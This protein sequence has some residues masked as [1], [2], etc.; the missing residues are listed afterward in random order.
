MALP[1]LVIAGVTKAGTSSLF[2]YLG[3]HPDI[4]VADVK[5]V[6]HYAPMVHGEPPPALVDY[7][8]HFRACAASPW[9]LEASPRYFIGGPPL[10]RRLAD[11]LDRPKVLIALREPVS[12]MWSSYTYKLSKNRLPEGMRFAAFV[13]A[14]REVADGGRVRVPAHAAFRTLATGVYA[15]YLG[16][17]FDVLGDD[18]RVVFFDDLAASPVDT[19][20]AVC[21][22][23]GVEPAAQLDTEVR[24]ATVQ[25]RSQALR[26][27]AVRLNARLNTVAGEQ[28]ALKARL[29]RVYQKVN[30]GRV[31]LE[32]DPV[33]RARVA[34]FYAP[35][36][37]PLRTMLEQRGYRTL[38][39]WLAP[40]RVTP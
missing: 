9:R 14:C 18:V 36:L 27:A 17:W 5:E 4:G 1:N 7:E 39:D 40:T 38:P 19:V 31:R 13:D 16:D 32:L 22:W 35:T 11:D 37:P 23:I 24:N 34:E 30:A 29:R 10:V 21:R 12:R 3:Q 26:R 25:P 33:D 15:D 20:A 2:H 6:D 8:R 28:S